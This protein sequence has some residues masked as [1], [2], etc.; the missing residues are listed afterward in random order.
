MPGSRAVENR[1]T[2]PSGS[3]SLFLVRFYTFLNPT[4]C[5]NCNKCGL[6]LSVL[7]KDN[8]GILQHMA[9]YRADLGLDSLVGGLGLRV[10]VP[11]LAISSSIQSA[12]TASASPSIRLGSGAGPPKLPAIC[13]P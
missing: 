3:M 5:I 1:D 9:E 10:L 13:A 11:Y 2:S 7:L 8:T 12:W 6:T 4:L